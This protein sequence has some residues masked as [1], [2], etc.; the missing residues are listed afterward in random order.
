MEVHRMSETYVECL[1]ARNGSPLLRFLKML[2]IMLTVVFVAV[3]M[4]FIPGL[5]VANVTGVAGYFSYMS[6]DL[7]YE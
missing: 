6:A 5:L 7:E 2:F 4:D 3:G 1:V